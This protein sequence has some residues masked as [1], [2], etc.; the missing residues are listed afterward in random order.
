MVGQ[1]DSNT[2]ALIFN[3]FLRPTAGPNVFDRK[4]GGKQDHDK[5]GRHKVK[6]RA[7]TC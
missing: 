7:E 2:L 3:T 6:Y 1:E 4:I 5:C